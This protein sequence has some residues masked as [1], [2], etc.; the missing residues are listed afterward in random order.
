DFTAGDGR[1]AVVGDGHCEAGASAG[2]HPLIISQLLDAQV[3]LTVHRNR[4]RIVIIVFRI[5]LRILVRSPYVNTVNYLSRCVGIYIGRYRQGDGSTQGNLSGGRHFGAVAAACHRGVAAGH[6]VTRDGQPC[7]WAFAQAN[8][9][10]TGYYR[11]PLIGNGY[12]KACTSAGDHTGIVRHFF[13]GQGRFADNRYRRHIIAVVFRIVLRILIRTPYGD[14]V[15][16]FLTCISSYRSRYTKGNSTPH[17][18]NSIRSYRST[19]TVTS[20]RSSSGYYF[21]IYN[22]YPCTRA[23]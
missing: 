21:I 10:T 11:W 6:F 16:D 22:R 13:D 17:R 20:Y 3:R 14:P 18:N 5:V 7:R 15:I 1:R 19:V 12:R 23:L 8:H 9:L 4:R 2:N